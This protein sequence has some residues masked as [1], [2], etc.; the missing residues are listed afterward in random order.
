[1]EAAVTLFS[2]RGFHGT[3]VRAIAEQ[4]GVALGLL[5]AHFP[6]KEA[7]LASLLDESMF[8]VGQTFV[9]ASRESTLQ[10][11]VATLL[12]SAVPILREHRAAW[13]V[14]YALR[15]EPE[16]LASLGLKLSAHAGE[17]HAFLTQAL[18][19]RH[20]PQPE[21]EAWALFGIV[22]GVLQAYVTQGDSYPIAEVVRSVAAKYAAFDQ[23]D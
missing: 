9:A 5:Y 2:Q 20:V 6:S 7:L 12:S 16:V 21:I 18:G 4:A 23:K 13:L 1:L 8:D 14:S 15:Y 19:E 17:I 3:S 11:F 22:D 10:G